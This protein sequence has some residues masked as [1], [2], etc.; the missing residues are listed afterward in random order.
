MYF[1]E[2][3]NGTEFKVLPFED[4]PKFKIYYNSESKDY[5]IFQEKESISILDYSVLSEEELFMQECA[6]DLKYLKIEEL[7]QI[8]IKLPYIIPYCT[9][10]SHCILKIEK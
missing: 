9:L 4:F 10:N 7:L 3:I 5:T 6:Y 2:R 8:Q 1:V